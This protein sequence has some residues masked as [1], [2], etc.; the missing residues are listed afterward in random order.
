MAWIFPACIMRSC[1]LYRKAS[2]NSKGFTVLAADYD[3]IDATSK[4]LQVNNVTT[5]MCAIGVL[6]ETASKSQLNL[7][8]AAE[9]SHCTRRFVIASYDMQHLPE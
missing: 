6:N 2:T 7:I 1:L 5:L 9:K 8:K 4:L 3:N